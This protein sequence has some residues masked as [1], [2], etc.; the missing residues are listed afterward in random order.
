MR[1]KDILDILDRIA[2]FKLAEEWDNVGLLTGGLEREITS[3]LVGLDPTGSLLDEA[4]DRKANTVITHHPLIFHP[5]SAITTSDPTGRIL[6]K[7]LT[8][9]INIIACHTNLDSAQNGVSDIL[10]EALG[11]EQ[12]TPLV[13]EVP[14]SGTGIGRIGNLAKEIEQSVFMDRLFHILEIEGVQVAGPLPKKI[15]RVA[16]CGGSGSDFAETAYKNGADVYL[17]AEVK[18]STARWAQECGFCIIDGT[19]YATEQPVVDHLVA[20]LQQA[21]KEEKLKIGIHK[22]QTQSHPFLYMNK[23]S[24][25]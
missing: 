2:P 13:Q 24:F 15:R 12:T 10:A 4:I 19:H 21:A 5:L 9:R 7:S 1:V 6:E 11:L 8:H 3:I 23:K 22:T 18:H 20:R 16:V 25:I 14:D 17:T